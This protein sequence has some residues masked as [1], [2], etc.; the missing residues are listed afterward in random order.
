VEKKTKLKSSTI[1]WRPTGD[2]RRP[3]FP[4]S[5]LSEHNA[6]ILK[7]P[8][9]RKKSVPFAAATPR[10]RAMPSAA[11]LRSSARRPGTVSVPSRGTPT[12]SGPALAM[13]ALLGREKGMRISHGK[14]DSARAKAREE[15]E[16]GRGNSDGRAQ[17]LQLF[18]RATHS[19]SSTKQTQKERRE[20][21]ASRVLLRQLEALGDLLRSLF[22]LLSPQLAF[23]LK[24]APPASFIWSSK[25]FP[26]WLEG[27][28]KRKRQFFLLRWSS[29]DRERSRSARS[30]FA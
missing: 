18:R 3:L 22:S 26:D 12:D 5:L 7:R 14:R 6:T 8:K 15:N 16:E 27:H 17:T 20:E 4:P 13:L 9:K 1:E 28:L 2:A 30:L 19:P 29:G 23:E 11:T 10:S 21:R 25:A 24:G